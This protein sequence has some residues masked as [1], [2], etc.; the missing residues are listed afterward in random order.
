MIYS[1]LEQFEDSMIYPIMLFGID[2]SVTDLSLGYI[3]SIIFL[4]VTNNNLIDTLLVNNDT[5]DYF[6][7]IVTEIVKE[8]LGMGYTVFL[9]QFQD[10]FLFIFSNNVAGL[11]PFSSS[12]TAQ[13]IIT[14][15]IA[16]SYN[17]YI[18]FLGFYLNGFYYLT[19][20]L[21]KNLALWLSLIII[22]IE[23][24]SYL[25][26]SLSLSVRLFANIV[27]GHA[28][29]HVMCFFATH[30]FFLSVFHAFITSAF[31]FMLLGLELLI[32]FIQAYIFCMLVAMYLTEILWL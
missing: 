13:I 2:L 32:A 31:L 26:R 7:D 11:I 6:D 18:I 20:F 1:P 23:V 14:G 10:L 25:L 24:F 19:I 8:Q 21:P 17:L 9:S 5:S 15:T 22:L 28:L 4:S 29:I 12:L 16:L 30:I 3:I 27:A